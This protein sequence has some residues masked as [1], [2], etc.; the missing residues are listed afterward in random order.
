MAKAELLKREENILPF[1][2]FDS[3]QGEVAKSRGQLIERKIE[4]L[5]S[6]T[7]KVSNRRSRRWLNDRL[8]IELVPRLNAD[9]I[10]GLFAPPPWG[11][12]TPL[13]AFCMTNIGEW[14]AFRHIDMDTEVTII[15]GLNKSTAKRKEQLDSDKVV[16]L[17]AWHRV[18]CRTREALKRNFLSDLVLGYEERVLAFIKDSGDADVLMLR[19][20][21]PFHRLLLHGVCEFYNLRSVTIS[22]LRDAKMWKMTK[23]MKKSHSRSSPPQI[24]LTQFLRMAKDGAL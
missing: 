2:I 22:T 20:Q 13:S 17:S 7:G 14:D 23:I 3:Q 10:R 15:Q 18:D 8:L 5:E 6:L 19:I 21:D 9:E 16:A 24:K 11:D 12:S 4:A 1:S